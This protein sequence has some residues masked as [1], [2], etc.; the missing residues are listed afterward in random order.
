MCST[1]VLASSVLFA[2]LG[3]SQ[4]QKFVSYPPA[5]FDRLLKG[6]DSIQVVDVR[7]PDEYVT[8]H[9]SNAMLIDV[10]DSLFMVKAN[11]LLHKS[12]PVAVYCRS[13]NRSKVAAKLLV[14]QGFKVYEL[15]GGF[16]AWLAYLKSIEKPMIDD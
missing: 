1:L 5:E 7:R 6:N 9:I 14:E 15:E 4:K 12:Q 3:C 10:S 8:G 11:L 2:C 13:G 16:L